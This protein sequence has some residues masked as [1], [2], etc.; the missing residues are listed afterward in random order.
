M[1]YSKKIEKSL[2]LSAEAV[3]C[4]AFQAD[5]VVLHYP[6]AAASPCIRLWMYCP[7]G[8]ECRLAGKAVPRD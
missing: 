7:P 4:T 5:E 2:S 8:K 6:E 3:F 1:R